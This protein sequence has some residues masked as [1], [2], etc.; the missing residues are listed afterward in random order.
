MFI[1]N[2]TFWLALGETVAVVG[3]FWQT[4]SAVLVSAQSMDSFL[5]ARNELFAEQRANIRS[6]IPRWRYLGRRRAIKDLE[7]EMG[8]ALTESERRLLRNFDRETWG[9]SA[10]F[11]AALVVCIVGW[12]QFRP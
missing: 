3:T 12:F 7:L 8:D 6:R 2:S 1:W 9:W 4:R 5:V 11:V 10:L